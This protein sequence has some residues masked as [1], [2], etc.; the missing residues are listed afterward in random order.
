[1]CHGARPTRFGPPSA[2]VYE[3]LDKPGSN[4]LRQQDE[5]CEWHTFRNSADQIVRVV[6]TSEP[7]E[8][9]QFLHDPMDA[10]LEKASRDLLVK[11]Y[12]Q[13]CDDKTIK[14]ADLQVSGT[15]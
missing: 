7:P 9:Y 2:A 13:I 11:L 14:L 4:G 6:F 8:Y 12:Q 3:M 5:Y 1:M 10:T 15:Y